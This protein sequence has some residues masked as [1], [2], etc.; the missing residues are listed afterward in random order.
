M[1]RI[2]HHSYTQKYGINNFFTI[3]EYTVHQKML[4][5]TWIFV[6]LFLNFHCVKM[7]IIFLPSQCG[8]ALDQRPC[9]LQFVL[10]CPFIT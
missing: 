7:N 5:K 8:L 1:L 2:L 3:L 6:E 9:L 10:V 4:I